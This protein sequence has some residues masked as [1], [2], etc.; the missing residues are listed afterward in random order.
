MLIQLTI[1]SSKKK[2]N[3]YSKQFYV[4]LYG[5]NYDFAWGEFSASISNI[6]S[7][8]VPFLYNS[9]MVFKVKT[10][11]EYLEHFAK[12]LWLEHYYN[13]NLTTQ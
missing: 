6:L 9:D 4:L 3:S 7:A 1:N 5:H 12:V 11:W 2:K 10:S 8:N 13:V